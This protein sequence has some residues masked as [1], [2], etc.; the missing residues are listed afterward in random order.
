MPMNLLFISGDFPPKP[1]GI[2]IY[3]AE[4]AR[5]VS[6]RPEVTRITLLALGSWE[7]GSEQTGRLAVVR[8]PR[9]ILPGQWLA[10]R[11]VIKRLKPDLIHV[12]TLF[13]EGLWASFGRTPYLVSLYGTEAAA[14]QGRRLTRWAKGRAVRRAAG[15]L[16][17]SRATAAKAAREFGLDNG[18]MEVVTPGL[19]FSSGPPVNSK[20]AAGGP[21]GREV[22]QRLGIG[23]GDFVVMT[24]GRLVARKGVD[25]LIRAL[26]GLPPEIKLLVVGDGPDRAR[27]DG[28]AAEMG[29]GSRV[30]LTGYVDRTGPY[31]QAA[32]VFALASRE[33]EGGDVEG[34]GIV[35]LEAQA[36]GLPVIGTSSGGIPE[37]FVEGSTG[38]LVPPARPEELARAIQTLAREEGLRRALGAAGPDLVKRAFNWSDRATALVRIYNNVLRG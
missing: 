9:G 2:G 34:F 20:P 10:V 31:Y 37:A 24:L 4:L 14:V 19:P 33:E 3:G 7:A 6:L 27:L 35:L 25:D 13:P 15:V 32:D 12:L 23:P 17:I 21:E 1:G 30:L 22:R 16:P 26:A 11:T 5:A 18:R 38:L 36:W 29:L 8:W 28:L